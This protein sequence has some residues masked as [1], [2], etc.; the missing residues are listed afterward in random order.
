MIQYLKKNGRL[1]M[2][3]DF[4]GRGVPAD[5]HGDCVEIVKNHMKK[6]GYGKA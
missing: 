6:T 1:N 4:T 2:N 3:S 5:Y